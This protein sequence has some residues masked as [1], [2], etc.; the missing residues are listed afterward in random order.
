MTITDIVMIAACCGF[1]ISWFLTRYKDKLSRKFLM[2]LDPL[3][4]FILGFFVFYLLESGLP[5]LKEFIVI[6]IFSLTGHLLI[7]LMGKNNLFIRNQFL[8]NVVDLMQTDL[9][10][11][12]EEQEKVKEEIIKRRK[13]K[14]QEKE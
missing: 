9:E 4:S 3:L 8:K 7:P 6:T 12:K 1:S 11:Y 10:K 14:E 5:D 2:I 13:K